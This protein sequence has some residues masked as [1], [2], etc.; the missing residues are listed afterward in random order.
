MDSQPSNG[1]FQK[2]YDAR[3]GKRK[4]EVY[5]GMTI[6]ELAQLHSNDCIHVLACITN[7]IDPDD[8]HKESKKSYATSS[9]IKAATL[10]LA[11]AH[12]KPVDQI[13]V[14]ETT[15][16]TQGIESLTTNQ[17]LNL[18]KQEDNATVIE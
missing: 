15:G 16:R 7:G 13:K 11:Y 8:P 2:G 9:R 14:L 5:K 4:V 1:Q 17:L 10:L 18:I 12:G 6:G 3:R